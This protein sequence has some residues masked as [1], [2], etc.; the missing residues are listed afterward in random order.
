MEGLEG[1]FFEI[2]VNVGSA[3]SFYIEAIAKAKTGD[4]EGALELMAEGQSAFLEGH[5]VHSELVQ[6]EASGEKIEMSLMLM[7]AEDQLMNA[8]GF[9]IVA[10]EFIDLYKLILSK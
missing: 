2:I 10:Q 5:K 6:M 1:K 7:H 3:K 4:I 8:D 9:K